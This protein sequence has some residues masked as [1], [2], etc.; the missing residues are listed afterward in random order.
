MRKR[1]AGSAGPMIITQ[2]ATILLNFLAKMHE[3]FRSRVLLSGQQKKCITFASYEV[4]PRT[5]DSR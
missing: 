3:K 1:Q 5:R 4:R 2:C